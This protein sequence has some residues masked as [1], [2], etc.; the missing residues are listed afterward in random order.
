MREKAIPK[1]P[2][3]C[4]TL[5]RAANAVTVFYDKAFAAAGISAS[6][7]ALLR[8]LERLG[9]ASTSDLAR[10]VQLERSTLVRNLRPLLEKGYLTDHAKTGARNHQYALS[11]A[12]KALLRRAEP[13][14]DAAQAELRAYLG[15]AE[16]ARLMETLYRLQAFPPDAAESEMV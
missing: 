7:F 1:S 14:W 15:G 13:C 6:Q 12:G 10:Q 2:C 11:E 9:R 8:N 3:H 4:I 16:T 5:R